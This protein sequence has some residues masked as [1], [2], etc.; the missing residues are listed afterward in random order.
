MK[1]TVLPNFFVVASLMR[2]INPA[3]SG[4]TALVP[5]MVV[6]LMAGLI[7]RINEATTKKFGKT[8]GFINP[9][10]Y[11]A[12]TQGVFRDIT[13]GNND[14]TGD[15]HGMYKAGPGWDACSGLGVPNG[16]ALQNLLS[17]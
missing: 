9:L 1:P 17:A 13:V 16:E 3:I 2:A 10:I 14:I 6:P 4:A 7:A 11:A 8:V 12:H 5:P 15:L